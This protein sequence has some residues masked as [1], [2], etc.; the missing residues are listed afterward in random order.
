MSDSTVVA[1]VYDAT[2]LIPRSVLFGNPEKASPQISPNGKML[3]YIAPSD[4]VLNVWVR[5]VGVNGERVV[6]H[7][8][9]RGIRMFF[10]QKDSAHVIFLQDQD[11]DENWHIYQTDIEDLQTRDLTPFS[12][13]HAQVVASSPDYPE[14]LLVGLNV[15][16]PQLIDVYRD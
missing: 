10:W 16:N 8:T 11:G 15:R 3:A 13:V 6:T 2:P 5:T 7:D 14:T 4:G 12:G 1:P 9:K